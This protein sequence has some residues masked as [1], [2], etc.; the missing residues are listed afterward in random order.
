MPGLR[1]FV[2]P[3]R[4]EHVV[5]SCGF[6]GAASLSVFQL[7]VQE[8][9]TQWALTTTHTQPVAKSFLHIGVAIVRR[10]DTSRA[11]VQVVEPLVG[12][13]R[14]AQVLDSCHLWRRSVSLNRLRRVRSVSRENC[15]WS[16]GA[17]SWLF[18]GAEKSTSSL[19]LS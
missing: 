7:W 5:S 1:V 14:V 4:R 19:S 6:G 17:L 2:H 10:Q 16:C 11:H 3:T 13:L 8:G 15:A 12:D 9:A 18:R